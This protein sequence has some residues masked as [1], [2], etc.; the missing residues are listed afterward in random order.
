MTPREVELKDKF[1]IDTWVLWEMNGNK[2]VSEVFIGWEGNLQPFDQLGIYEVD[3]FTALTYE[4]V[5]ELNRK[6]E[7]Y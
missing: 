3:R 2:Y 7:L 6:G 1:P 5:E 4:E